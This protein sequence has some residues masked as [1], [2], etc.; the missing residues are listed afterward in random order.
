MVWSRFYLEEIVPGLVPEGR[1]AGS[2]STE[3]AEVGLEG[4]QTSPSR[5]DS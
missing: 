5:L 3:F 2:A 1:R 4:S